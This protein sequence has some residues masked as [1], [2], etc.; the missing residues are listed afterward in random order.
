MH[1]RGVDAEP[2]ARDVSQSGQAPPRER[3]QC[4]TRSLV[5]NDTQLE[6]GHTSEFDLVVFDLLDRAGTE[7]PLLAQDILERPSIVGRPG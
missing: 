6:L 1:R 2:Q 7:I 4:L 5:W 3:R